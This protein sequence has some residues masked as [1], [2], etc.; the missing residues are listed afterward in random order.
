MHDRDSSPL[1]MWC[2]NSARPNLDIIV[3][4]GSCLFCWCR[5]LRHFLGFMILRY[6]CKEYSLSYLNRWYPLDHRP[7]PFVFFIM[8]LLDLA[9]TY[10]SLKHP[11]SLISSLKEV[12]LAK[13]ISLPMKLTEMAPFVICNRL[14]LIINQCMLIDDDFT[15]SAGWNS[16]Q[17]KYRRVRQTLKEL[18]HMMMPS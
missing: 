17:L 2:F 4:S 9:S 7:L 8:S 15:A 11:S 13:Q 12:C 6:I 10:R 18:D 16:L 14:V 3:S 1:P 5:F